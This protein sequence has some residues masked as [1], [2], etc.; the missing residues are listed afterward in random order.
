MSYVPRT[1]PEIVRDLLT[2]LTGGVVRETLTADVTPDRRL[3]DAG[4][5]AARLAQRPVRRISHLAGK[6]PVAGKPVDYRFTPA[7][8]E[9]VPSA[10]GAEPDTIRFR[11]GAPQPIAGTTL[12]VNYYPVDAREAPLTDL[13]VGSVVRTLMESVA[14]EL[15]TLYEQMR[16]VYDSAFVETAEGG[17][18]DKA[19]ALVGVTRL[20]SGHPVA[21]VR[22]SRRPG[23]PGRLTVPSGTAIVDAQGNRYLTNDE[24]TLEPG[25][26]ARVVTAR[27]E[28]PATPVVA[29]HALTRPEVV[30]AGVGEV[31]NPEPGRALTSAESDAELRRRA[32]GA[33]H[34]VVHG[35]VD[36][37]RFRLLTL[38]FVKDVT[39]DE[40]PNG[41][42]GEVAVTV[43]Y[44]EDTPDNR[45]KVADVIRRVRPAGIRVL[46]AS[47]TPR[48]VDADV[49]VVV[50]GG[51]PP[52]P[53]EAKAISDGAAERVRAVLAAVPPGGKVRRAQ[54]VTAVLQDARLVD[55]SVTLTPQGGAAAEEYQVPDGGVLE[56]GT[57][58]VTKLDTEI[59]AGT[60]STTSRVDVMLPVHLVS[61][62]TR[63]DAE[64]AATSR[65]DGYLATVA[66]DKPLTADALLS[67]VADNTRYGAV[68]AET[69]VTVSAGD[70]FLQLTDGQGTYQPLPGETMARGTLSFDVR[71]G[72]V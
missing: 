16:V 25:E 12:V 1:Y 41:I 8:F 3:R 68:R 47:A 45:A 20:P 21:S 17:S 56:P 65:L 54:L 11:P 9:L 37:L 69:V 2:T 6:I 60:V 52:S 27:G 7:D 53:A 58:A 5:V 72:T 57:V 13:N 33:L 66:P 29:A 15:A 18:L 55:A 40:F 70:R 51:T 49:A 64:A 35:T 59:A 30:I 24:L 44:A 14:R 71:D 22:F 42:A 32:R 4:T 63:A 50:A 62:V 61:G 26:E 23:T 39:I 19:V 28:S 43:A 46:D 36:A 48:R 38:D 31:D 10:D 67:A 34:G